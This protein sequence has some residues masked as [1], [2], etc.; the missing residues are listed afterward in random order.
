[1]QA[2]HTILMVSIR[3][4]GGARGG[5]AVCPGACVAG[6]GRW[7][8]GC[9][10]CILLRPGGMPASLALVRSAATNG[11]CR[12]GI[13]M[14]T[15]P[16]CLSAAVETVL[17]ME[18]ARCFHDGGDRSNFCTVPAQEMQQRQTYRRAHTPER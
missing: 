8:L 11:S 12:G 7:L 6:W 4:R 9:M 13:M 2:V 3:A 10:Q 16:W 15:E 5:V 17:G 1:M 14:T 18:L